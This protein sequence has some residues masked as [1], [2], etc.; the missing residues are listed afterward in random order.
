M[1][2]TEASTPSLILRQVE[3]Y[4]SDGS[5][6][7]DEYLQK[8]ADAEG[9][10]GLDVIA[11]FARMQKLAPDAGIA[12]I[13]AAMAESD[14]CELSAD[15]TRIKRSFPLPLDDPDKERTIH[16]RNFPRETLEET[17]RSELE[18]FGKIE[19]VRLLRNLAQDSR[20]RDGSAF[21]VFA[22]A[23]SAEAAAAAGAEDKPRYM[24][25]GLNI[26]L[27]A[28]WF[29]RLQKQRTAMKATSG[30]RKADGDGDGGGGSSSKKKRSDKP[31]EPEAAVPGAVLSCTGLGAETTREDLKE[32]CGKHGTVAWV[33]YEKG[34]T[35]ANVRFDSEGAATAAAAAL[36]GA[37]AELCGATPGFAVLEGEGETAFWAKLN[38]DKKARRQN[39]GKGGKGGRGGKGGKG[40]KG[41][42]GRR[43]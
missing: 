34:G 18:Q 11:K 40:G 5:Y 35:E 21:V 42:R 26:Y 39:S 32:L 15:S 33:D 13:A 7:F 1:A 8:E 14:S 25:E 38:A 27:L 9:F 29:E 24:G 20:F 41:G 36:A 30:K 2:A 3:Y 12:S 22:E 4:L 37:K 6:P 19:R 31:F 10:I 23:A 17:F 16:V 28:D 43:N